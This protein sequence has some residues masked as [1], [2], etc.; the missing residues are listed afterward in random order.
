[1]GVASPGPRRARRVTLALS[2]VLWCGALILVTRRLPPP[3]VLM[4]LAALWALYV[5]VGLSWLAARVRA[6]RVPAQAVLAVVLCALLGAQ[7]VRSRAVLESEETDWI[8]MRD[9][10]DV[11]AVVAGAG[12]DERILINPSSGP[13]LDYYLH[14][15]TGRRLADFSSPQRRGRVLLVLD[16]RHGQTLRRL[17]PMYR[18]IVGMPPGTPV[19]LRQFA[20]ASV[21][22]I[23]AGTP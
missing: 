20:G 19:L 13:P 2:T 1:V 12:A 8:G 21:Y 5:G 23:P 16:E 6:E 9:A 18:E 22:A 17:L 7:V 3:R 4:F 11:A 14:R 10:R 15:L